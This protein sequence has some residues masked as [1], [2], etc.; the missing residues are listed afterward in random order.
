[1]KMPGVDM[2]VTP[3]ARAREHSPERRARTARCRATSDDEHAV[4]TVSAGPCSPSVYATR[5]EATLGVVPVS[6]N[7]AA[8]APASPNRGPYSWAI[9]PRNTPVSLPCSE[10]GVI[11]A[12]SRAS[13]EI[14]SSSRCCGSIASASR[15]E[16]PKNSGSNSAA[17]WRKPPLRT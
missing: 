4:S 8:P 14:S 10:A 11:P 16:I 17:S 1:M 7:P 15:G 5:P 6:P 2:T 12:R 9:A 13:Q 3:P